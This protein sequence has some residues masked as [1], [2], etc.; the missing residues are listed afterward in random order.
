MRLPTLSETAAFSRHVVTFGSGVLAG[1]VALGLATPDQASATTDALKQLAHG[2]GE[3]GAA[4]GTIAATGM[5]VW[6]AVRASFPSQ[7]SA[8]AAN[9]KVEQVVTN[10]PALAQATP[11]VK[12]V[13]Q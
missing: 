6:A 10:D 13:S 2:V 5:G 7:L 8:V 11:S 9:P 3:V 12:V 4:L 1:A